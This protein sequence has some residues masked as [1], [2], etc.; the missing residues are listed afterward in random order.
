MVWL[1]GRWSRHKLGIEL[2]TDCV[3]EFPE[4]GRNLWRCETDLRLWSEHW[5]RTARA[6]RELLTITSYS[7]L[8]SY[9][10]M[11]A[12]HFPSDLRYV[13]F[14]INLFHFPGYRLSA[15]AFPYL[16][17][18][19]YLYPPPAVISV[20][21]FPSPSYSNILSMINLL[22]AS[23]GILVIRS[24]RILSF[25]SL[26]QQFHTH[27]LSGTIPTAM[28]CEV[29]SVGDRLSCSHYSK[30][31]LCEARWSACP[32]VILFIHCIFMF[33]K[34]D[35]EATNESGESRFDRKHHI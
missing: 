24:P 1:W 31:V 7:R 20:K 16:L 18:L 32:F 26:E 15:I 17:S 3:N 34:C 10:P 6:Y 27:Y 2:H 14:T 30:E 28:P 11:I 9:T 22:C 19:D 8:N 23:V 13:I 12:S 21:R 5:C 33:I 29:I 35:Q 25:L 4:A